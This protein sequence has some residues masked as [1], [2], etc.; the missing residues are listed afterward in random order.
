MRRRIASSLVG[1]VLL[2]AFVVSCGQDAERSALPTS[3]VAPSDRQS[4]LLKGGCLTLPNL[5]TLV[6][7]VFDGSPNAVLILLKVANL[8]AQ[9]RQ[10][11]TAAAQAQARDIVAMIQAKVA[12]GNVRA[13]R[14]QIQSLISGI[15]CFAGLSPDTF[16]VLPSDQTQVL[17]SN[18]GGSGVMLPPNAV[19]EPALLTITVLPTNAPP[20]TTKLD[21]YPGFILL[22]QTSPLTKPAVVGVCPASGIDPTVLARLRL[23]HQATAGFE[24]TPAA[25]AGFLDCSTAVGQ[26][27]FGKLLQRVAKA[28]LP[29]PLYAKTE[30]RG[31]IGGLVSEF[32]PFAPVDPEL[33]L[34]GG[35]GGLVSEF[36]VAP[37]VDGT[38]AT[39]APALPKRPSGLT[40]N[41][42]RAPDARVNTV[43]NGVC[44]QADATVG[45]NIENECRPV[46]TIT[47]FKGTVF[48][49]VPVGWADRSGRRCGS[50]SGA[51]ARVRCIRHDRIDDDQCEWQRERLLAAR[52]TARH[53]HGHRDTDTR[54]GRDRREHHVQPE[55]PHVHGRRQ[56]DRSNS[57]CDGRHVRL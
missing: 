9:V 28:L 19:N 22:T 46:V 1:L 50:G 16:L 6:H 41:A 7:V 25:D 4:N 27:T 10:G 31:G 40:P 23:G 11:N 49:T 18:G 37:P 17:V 43:V 44:T 5:I 54:R 38:P 47:T 42:S 45:T 36:K 12:Q 34:R 35:I 15:L 51:R 21:Q 8:D 13:T 48:Q 39:P 3:P 20:L 30:F 14:D 2:G 29:K 33:N 26:S 52:R 55:E 32:S 53:Q 56:A 24:I 57:R